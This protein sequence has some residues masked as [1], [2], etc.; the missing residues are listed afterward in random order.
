[1][2]NGGQ[3]AGRVVSEP[4]GYKKTEASRFFGVAFVLAHR[5]ESMNIAGTG[6]N[7]L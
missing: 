4:K 7:E 2:S 5:R 1:M 3:Q 6:N